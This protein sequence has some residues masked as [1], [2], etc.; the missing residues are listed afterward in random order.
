APATGGVAT[1]LT[2]HQGDESMPAISP[3]GKTVAFTAQYEGP[4]EVYTMPLAGGAPTR[5][6]YDGTRPMIASWTPDGRLLYASDARSGLPSAQLFALNIDTGERTLIPLA[7]AADGAF[8]DSGKALF[9][10][11]LPFQ[12]SWTKR[13]KGGTIQHLWRFSEGD[14]EATP[15]TADFPGTSKHAMPRGGRVCFLTDRPGE[16]AGNTAMNIWSMK[17][18]GSDLK[19]H[20]QSIG[21]DVMEANLDAAPGSTRIAY[22]VRADVRIFDT[23]TGTDL[24]VPLTLDTDLDQTR[25][26]FVEK[27]LDFLTSAHLSPDGD[28]IVV[29]IRGRVFVLPARQGRTIELTRKQ[30]IRLREA[31]FS[32]DGTSIITL[33][34]ESGEVEIHRAPA[35]GVGPGEQ[36]SSGATVLRR[37]ALMSPDG[38][39]IATHDHRQKL[40][41]FATAEKTIE[42]IDFDEADTLTSMAWS[43]DSQ[44]LAYTISATN[45][46]RQVRLYNTADKSITPATSDRF[47]S[48]DPAWTAD[49]KFLAF[50]SDRNLVSAVE[51]PWGPYQPEPYLHKKS[52]IYL[53]ALTAEAR[54]PFAQR[55]EVTS[56]KKPDE[57]KPDEKKPEEKKPEEKKPA[58][59]VKIEREGL[60]TRLHEVPVPAG[61]YRD[62]SANDKG[63]FFLSSPPTPGPRALSAIKFDNENIEIKTVVADVASYELSLDGKKLLLRKGETFS[64]IDAVPPAG[65][66]PADLDKKSVPLSGITLSTIPKE[67]WRQHFVDAWRLERDYFY[68]PKMHGVDWPA[69]REKYAPLVDRITTRAELNDVLAQMVSELSALHIFVR[70]GDLRQGNDQIMPSSLG[71]VLTR[72]AAAGGFTVTRIYAHDPD[73]PER[74]APL[75]RPTTRVKE[76]ETILAINGVPTLSVADPA[77]L[78]RAK[79]GQQVL[80]RIRDKAG[81]ERDAIAVPFSMQAEADLRYHEWELSRRRM[82]ETAG[83]GEIGYVHLRAM[84]GGDWTDFAKGFYPVFNRKGLIIDVRHNR[85]GNIDSWVIEKLLRKAWFGWS[86]AT[87]NPPQWNM[88]YAFRGHVVVLCNERTASDGEAFAEG[89]KRLNIGTVI[90]TRTWGGE[91]WLSSSN[92]LADRGIATAAEIGVYG[93]EG[94]WLIEGHGVDPDVVVDNLPHATFKGKDAQLE[95]AIAHLKKQITEKPIAPMVPPQRPDKSGK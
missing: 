76:G 85:G 28:R 91:I 87:G 17:P 49:G 73:E 48:Y 81:E 92:V 32:P 44:W 83:S 64:I 22:R 52:K 23:A 74:A 46:F 89:V 71:A 37:D 10:T 86:P 9:F 7:Q 57:K 8:D 88:Q 30:G 19:Q 84:G 38:R 29:T 78:L 70:G 42:E 31:R 45:M 21:F 47:D 66:S 25:E 77:L 40:S 33:S 20:T 53:L 34:D 5:R 61:T 69:M 2:S 27:P 13:Y 1:R 56:A 51:S 72:D 26:R 75:A 50:I 14:T 35:H 93:P 94:A 63:L 16:P 82:T 67:E 11:R 68:D 90:G 39:F 3:D 6:T 59:D 62:L 55:D 36:L 15:L 79:A 95:A 65:S 80:L 18:D 43:P 24:A 54:S 4:T 60:A 12:G 58:V 41:I